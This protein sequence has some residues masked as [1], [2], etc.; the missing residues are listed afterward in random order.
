MNKSTG[1]FLPLPAASIS[2]KVKTNILAFVLVIWT[3]ASLGN[4]AATYSSPK[5]VTGAKIPSYIRFF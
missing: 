2:F 1:I 3:S 4:P 5:I